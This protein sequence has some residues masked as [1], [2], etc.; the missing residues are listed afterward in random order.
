MNARVDLDDEDGYG[1][2]VKPEWE[3]K[4]LKPVHQSICALLAQGKRNVDIARLM[5][6][7]PEYI[8]ML[9]RQ[10][11]IKQEIARISEVAGARLEAMFEQSVDVIAETM[12]NG[13][14][15][16]KLKAARLQLEATKRIGRPD[17]LAGTNVDNTDRLERLAERLLGL[18]SKMQIRANNEVIEE[19]QFREIG[20][21]YQEIG[22]ETAEASQGESNA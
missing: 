13:N 11:L 16:N 18:Q 6:V 9:L 5:D 7:T 17:P 2:E 14:H 21:P 15:G 4:K 10:Q 19:V 3:M 12:Q 1:V 8:T 22:C 20:Q